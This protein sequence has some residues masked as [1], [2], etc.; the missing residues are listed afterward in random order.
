LLK[1][2]NPK[3]T[4]IEVEPGLSWRENDTVALPSTTVRWGD[5]D[6]AMIKTYDNVTGIATIDRALSKYHWGASVSTAPQYSGVDMRGEV[7]LLTKNIKIVGNNTDAWGCQILTSDFQEANNEY[8]VGETYMDNVE[9]Y[10]C[11]QYDTYKAAIRFEDGKLGQSKI[12][13][14]AIHHGLGMAVNIE[15]SEN[16]IL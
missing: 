2:A 5:I 13:N 14:S 12:S 3:E 1:T 11:S 9:V 15:F 16:I 8:R 4:Q 10:N 7:M 6:F